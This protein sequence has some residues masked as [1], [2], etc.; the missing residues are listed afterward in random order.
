MTVELMECADDLVWD[1][2]KRVQNDS[3]FEPKQSEEWVCHLTR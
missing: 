1:R 2:S 3:G